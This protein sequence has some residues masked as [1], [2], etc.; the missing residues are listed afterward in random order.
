VPGTCARWLEKLSKV[1]ATALTRALQERG[2]RREVPGT[3]S[4]FV[5]ILRKMGLEKKAE[6]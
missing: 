1:L 3:Y 6:P 2:A 4:G 5:E